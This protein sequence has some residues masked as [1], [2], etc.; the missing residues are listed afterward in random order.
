MASRWCVISPF[1]KEEISLDLAEDGAWIDRNAALLHHLSQ[2][3]IDDCVLAAPTHAQQDDLDWEAPAL[4]QRQ[5]GG[6]LTGR[7]ALK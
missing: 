3:V 4:E 6:S 2:I 7:L 5:K 1:L